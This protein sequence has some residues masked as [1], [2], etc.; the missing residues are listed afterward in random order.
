MPVRIAIGI[1]VSASPGNSLAL[2]GSGSDNEA[3]RAPNIGSPREL[4]A[5][6]RELAGTGTQL[7]RGVGSD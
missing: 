3:E 4:V 7:I 5:F 6:F 2:D 1:S